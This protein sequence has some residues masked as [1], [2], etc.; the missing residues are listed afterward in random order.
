M[1]SKRARNQDRRDNERLRDEAR[2]QLREGKPDRARRLLEAAISNHPSNTRYWHALGK[3]EQGEGKVEA[4]SRAFGRALDLSPDY[5]PARR[6]LKKLGV[7]RPAP[8]LEPEDPEPDVPTSLELSEGHDWEMVLESLRRSGGAVLPGLVNLEVITRLDEE[9][10]GR[11]GMPLDEEG[12]SEH[13]LQVPP[14]ALQDLVGE[15]IYRGRVLNRLLRGLLSGPTPPAT[16]L[17]IG[18]AGVLALEDGLEELRWPKAVGES[19][20]PIELALPLQGGLAL[21]FSDGV[22]G[23]KGRQRRPMEVQPGDALVLCA[24]E[25]AVHIGGV[26]GRQGLVVRIVGGREQRILRVRLG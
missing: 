7:P 1:T 10:A 16:D 18:A 2:Q 5:G 15:L 26:W 20:F 6:A 14:E 19:P 12:A 3:L 22:G 13:L 24:G 25:R 4:A 9:H 23:K 11:P 8:T 17:V 21:E